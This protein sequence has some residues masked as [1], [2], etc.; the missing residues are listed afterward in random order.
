MEFG[1]VAFRGR[2]Y[3]H[4]IVIHT[5][6]TVKK[7]KKKPSKAF[8]GEYGHTPLSEYELA[9]LADE[10]PVAVYIGT[11]YQ[12][13]LPLTPGAQSLLAGYE[14]HVLPTAELMAALEQE[15]RRIAAIVHV[16]C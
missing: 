1:T 11:G 15:K 7:R 8:R 3:D 14:T 13:A 4:D 6:G 12:G 2:E 9:F 5:D 10:K 16:T